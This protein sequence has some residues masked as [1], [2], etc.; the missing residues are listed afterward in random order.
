[1]AHRYAHPVPRL[2]R[3]RRCAVHPDNAGIVVF[4]RNDDD[5]ARRFIQDVQGEGVDTGFVRMQP[6]LTTPFSTVIVDK[7]GERLVVPVHVL[8][9]PYCAAAAWFALNKRSSEA[10]NVNLIASRTST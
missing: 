5:I 3:G 2:P 4:F 6:G 10:A 7:H 9:I 8:L 1:M